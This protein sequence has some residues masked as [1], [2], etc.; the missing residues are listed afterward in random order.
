MGT[1]VFNTGQVAKII[2]SRWVI[3]VCR[4]CGRKPEINQVITVSHFWQN[5]LLKKK[6]KN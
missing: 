3:F 4:L 5:Y 6:K 2:L 1:L